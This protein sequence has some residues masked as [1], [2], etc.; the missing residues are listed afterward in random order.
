MWLELIAA[1]AKT[2]D[3]PL[4]TAPPASPIAITALKRSLNV[5]LPAELKAFLQET[6]GLYS[7]YDIHLMWP[8]QRIEQENLWFRQEPTLKETC[9]PFD[10]LLFFAD[11]GNGDQF[12]YAIVNGVV[13]H[14][15]IYVW[16][17]EDDSRTCIAPSLHRFLERWLTGNLHV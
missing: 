6:D 12:A 14:S 7:D 9:M 13:P 11:A 3:M 5:T 1:W 16:N 17:H 8:V 4:I 2:S 10:P 15:R